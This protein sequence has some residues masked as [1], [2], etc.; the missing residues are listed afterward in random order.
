MGGL[1]VTVTATIPDLQS[2]I[3]VETCT[4]CPDLKLCE[5][6]SSLND[7]TYHHMRHIFYRFRNFH[8]ILK[9]SKHI[10]IDECACNLVS[11]S[12]FVLGL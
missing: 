12:A 2:S 9:P 3:A 11:Y 1:T 8:E 10:R 7:L 5:Y 6:G 4:L